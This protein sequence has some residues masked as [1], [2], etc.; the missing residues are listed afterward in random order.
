MVTD[1]YLPRVNGVARS[2][3]SFAQQFREQGHRVWIFAPEFPDFKDQEPD[4]VRFPSRFLSFD[5]EDRLANMK[6]PGSLALIAKLSEYKLD[7]IHNQTP[8]SLGLAS[9]RWARHLQ[10]PV[11]HTYHTLFEAYVHNYLK[12]VPEFVG[13]ASAAWFSR[14]YCNKHD[15]IIAPSSPMADALKG[16]GV[17]APIAINPT[18]IDLTPFQNLDGERMRKQ[19]GFASDDIMLLAMGRVAREKNLPFLLDVLERMIPLQPKARL[20]IA[21]LGPALDEIKAEVTRR[22]LDPKVVYIGYLNRKDWADLYAAAELHLLA[23]VT[24]TQGMVLT[25]AMAAGTPCVAVAAMG[26]KDVMADG[27]GLAVNLDLAEYTNAVQRL[28]TDKKLY[29][30]KLEEAKRQAQNWSIQA[31]AK[32]LLGKYAALVANRKKP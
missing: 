15:L 4:V 8:F 25:E 21:G 1:T 5:P 19:L 24:E 29:A 31:K 17:K 14:W 18:G 23:S 12:W 6:H 22:R 9:I 7:I 28:L 30:E 20:V 16:Y 3:Q 10:I 26:V 13:H 2:V 32:E 11:V 27:G